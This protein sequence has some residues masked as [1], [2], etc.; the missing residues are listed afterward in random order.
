MAR[1]E[2][3]APTLVPVLAPYIDAIKSTITF[4]NASG[5][6]RPILF[7]PLMTSNWLQY[8]KDGVCFQVVR[9]NKRSDILAA[10]GRWVLHVEG[11][12]A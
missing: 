5:V 9:R 4:A 1:L 7:N 8:F 12:G 3:I 10:G 6:T 11:R 2:K